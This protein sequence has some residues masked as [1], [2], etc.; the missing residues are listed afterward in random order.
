MFEIFC[1]ASL[2]TTI[3]IL[4][5][6]SNIIYEYT[7]GIINFEKYESWLVEVL[8]S[9]WYEGKI[10]Y[11]EYIKTKDNFFTKLITCPLCLSFWICLIYVYLS[12]MFK[13]LPVL[14][15]TALLQFYA[16][17]FFKDGK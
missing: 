11:S 8:S 15:I 1:M 3:M 16:I 4:W 7:K 13:M 2:S 14:Y 10:N 5:L 6:E 9:E 17:R 12:G